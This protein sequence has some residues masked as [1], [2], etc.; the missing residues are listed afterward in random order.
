MW[1]SSDEGRTWSERYS[2]NIEDQPEDYAWSTMGEAVLWQ[3]R[4]GK[5][6]TILRVDNRGWPGI[7]GTPLELA[8]TEL[9]DNFDRMTLYTSTDLGRSWQRLRDFG[10]YGYMYPSV[11]RLQDGRLLLTFTHRAPNRPKGLRAIL[12]TETDDGFDFDFEHDVIMIDEKTPLEQKSGGGFGCTVQLDDGT[13][14]SSYSYRSAPEPFAGE[15]RELH[16]EIARWRAP[17]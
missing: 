11:L 15:D 6:Y 3:A 16:L 9:H 7:D 12:G 8:S 13:L 2:A 4:S 10:T 5:M 1:R 17:V 14:V